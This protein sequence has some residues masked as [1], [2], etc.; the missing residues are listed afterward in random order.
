MTT[1]AHYQQKGQI[2]LITLDSP[3]VN[4]LGHPLRQAIKAGL[5]TALANPDVKAIVIASAGKLFC[6]GADIAEFASGGFDR[7]PRLPQLLVDI[8][9]A[10]KPVVAAINGMALGGGFEL[11]LACDYRIALPQAKCG[12]PEVN[13][14]IL[15]GAGGTQRL[16]RLIGAE[17]AL[18]MGTSGAPV[19][20]GKLLQAGAIDR[21]FEGEPADFVAAAIAYAEELLAQGA[22]CKTCADLSVENPGAEFFAEFRQSIARKTRGFFAPERNIQCIEAACELPLAEGLA[23]EAELFQQCAASPQ[24]RAQQH[25]FFA[26]RAATKIPG[27]DPKTPLRPIAKVGVIGA[28]TMG[29]G[30]AMNFANA[31]I[32]VTLLEVKPEALERGL[33]VIRNNYEIS[34]KKGRLSEAQVEERMGLIQGSLDYADLAQVDVVIEAVF[35]NMDIKKQVFAQLDKTCKPGAILAT[36][37]STLDVDEIAAATSRPQD[38]IGL[39]FFS[40]ANVMRLLEIVRGAKTADDVL[41]TTIKMAQTIRK[42][43]VVAG[44]CWG[45]IGNRGLEPYGREAARLVMEGASPEQIDKVLYH[46]GLAMGLP[47]M[48]DLAGID[49]GYLTRQGNREALYGRDDAYAAVCDALYEAGHYGQ[50]TGKGFYIYEGRNKQSNPEVIKI[51]EALA[52]KH[53]IARRQISDQEILERCLYPLINEG[54]QILDEGIAYRASDIDVIYC[55][56]YGF[57]VYRGGPMQYADEIG[58]DTVVE[59]L[60]KYQSELGDYGQTW[61]QVSPLL[62]RLASEGKTFKQFDRQ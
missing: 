50:K 10:S 33:G 11:A 5:E 56:G 44:V 35:E 31:G 60:K 40:P 52:A 54:A 13:I 2:A 30:I 18:Q 43:P 29:G 23:K 55:N 36:N 12:L 14:G 17:M 20:T 42:M 34:A 19:A 32:P 61:F 28:G 57:P 48:I 26:E 22:P 9:N 3:P 7:E 16:P 1:P 47:S 45:F 51:A 59:A 49:V 62:Q 53:G 24:A 8:E 6:G 41:M 37:T 38:V 21:I 46:W 39:H 27:V 15:P 25:I 58:L 4:G